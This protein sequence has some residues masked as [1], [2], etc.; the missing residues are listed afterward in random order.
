[1]TPETIQAIK[2][3]LQPVAAKIGQGTEF[4]WEVVVR[5]QYVEAALGT[6]FALIFAPL[7]AYF[8][9]W[10]LRKG[11]EI[12]KADRWANYEFN[13]FLGGILLVFASLAF[14]VGTIT[15]VTHFI[16]PEFYALKF[17]IELVKPTT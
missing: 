7:A 10:S 15:A 14:V 3:A 6:L 1:M 11:A 2:E 8:G 16:N 9:A 17:F 13:Y 5:Q 4:G 12:R